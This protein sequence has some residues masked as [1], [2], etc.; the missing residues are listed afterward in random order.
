MCNEIEVSG[1]KGISTLERW[2]C[3]LRLFQRSF[4]IVDKDHDAY[5]LKLFVSQLQRKE[6]PRR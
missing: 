6:E 5:I 4:Q 2:S 1:T 3:E